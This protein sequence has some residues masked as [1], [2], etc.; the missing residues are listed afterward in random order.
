[1]FL[2]NT[3][4]QIPTLIKAAETFKETSNHIVATLAKAVKRHPQAVIP[5][6]EVEKLRKVNS[7]TPCASPDMAYIS[8]E[9][10][11]QITR[12]VANNLTPHIKRVAAEALKD[13]SV[14]VEYFHY[15]ERNLRESALYRYF[16]ARKAGPK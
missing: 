13:A 15:I 1:M 7:T 10:A 3:F 9:I 5:D 16:R 11:R 4:S 2:R 14:T 8:K 12:D 6:S